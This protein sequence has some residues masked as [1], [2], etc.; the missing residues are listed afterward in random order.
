MQT[1][2]SYLEK[3]RVPASE[4]GLGPYIRRGNSL[5]II[6][7]QRASGMGL[8][9]EKRT[10]Y[11]DCAMIAKRLYDDIV[12][13][14][15]EL[16]PRAVCIM[17]GFSIHYRVEVSDPASGEAA[18]IDA[19]PWYNRVIAGKHGVSHSWGENWE[20]RKISPISSQQALPMSVNFFQGGTLS[21]YVAGW[22]P[23]NITDSDHAGQ[24][25]RFRFIGLP[26]PEF[27]FS[28]QVCFSQGPAQQ[29]N[30]HDAY[31]Q[32]HDVPAFRRLSSEKDFGQ[33]VDSGAIKLLFMTNHGDVSFDRWASR[34][35]LELNE[36]LTAAMRQID[37]N[38]PW[39]LEIMRRAADLF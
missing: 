28:L 17:D 18:Q 39:L 34:G 22:L 31:F 36:I 3:H 6:P 10:D 5:S 27:E 21:T 12:R 8:V 38:V 11:L 25:E 32:V 14:N 13:Q 33:L 7:A 16:S 20:S 29:L 4:F 37:A 26:L 1:A 24:M 9:L 23:K 30:L 15:P 19:T 35:I 2:K